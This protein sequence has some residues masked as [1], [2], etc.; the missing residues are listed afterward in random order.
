MNRYMKSRTLWFSFLLVIFGALMDNFSYLQSIID[1][2]YYGISFVA[3]GLITAALRFI[4][5]Q[6]LSDK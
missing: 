2:R 6:G 4:T 1:E 3:I 5:T